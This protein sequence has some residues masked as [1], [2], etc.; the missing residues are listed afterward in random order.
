GR[1]APS[2]SGPYNIAA[3]WV[4]PARGAVEGVVVQS[5]LEIWRRDMGRAYDAPNPYDRA[6]AASIAALHWA[7]H[8]RGALIRA[9]VRSQLTLWVA[10]WR[11]TW[12]KLLGRPVPTTMILALIA[13][14]TA[15]AIALCASV[16]VVV[17]RLPPFGRRSVWI[18]LAYI[19]VLSAAVG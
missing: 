6:D 13:W 5:N 14:R 7:A 16:F 12:A 18:L 1:L 2:A 10:P 17:R 3:L 15:L 8:H 9:L 19:A 11:G 4:G